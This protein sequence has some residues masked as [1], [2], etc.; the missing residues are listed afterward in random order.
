M[1]NNWIE[2]ELETTDLND[3]RLDKRLSE[4][5]DT[6]AARPHFSIPAACGGYAETMAAYRFF[7]NEKTNF[8]NVLQPH[9][10][11]TEKRFAKHDTVL[12]V[13]DTTELNLTR[14]Q[15]QIRGAG[16][17]GE[18]SNRRGAYLHLLAA[19]SPDA[20]PLGAVWAKTIVRE[21]KSETETS[22]ER[23][24]KLPFLPI[25]EKESIRWL[26][27]VRKTCDAAKRND[28]TRFVCVGDSE[29]DIFEVFAEP[30]PNHVHL[31]IRACQ[32][33]SV[34][35]E[36]EGR[37]HLRDAVMASPVRATKTIHVRGRVPA[38]SCC[39]SPRQQP[40]KSRDAEMEVRTASLTV[41]V[42]GPLKSKYDPVAMN[43]VSLTEKNPPSGDVPI[44]WIL[45]T[46][47]P[48]DT[49]EQVFEAIGYYETRW[50]I[51]VFFKTLKS[52]C[53]V[54]SL[55]F[56]TMDRLTPCLAVYLIV[57]WRVLLL[58]RLGR[59]LPEMNCEA[60]FDESEWK[61]L[62]RIRNPNDAIPKTPPTLGEMLRWVGE[63]GGWVSTP[64]KQEMPGPQTTWIGLQRLKDFASA[65]RLFGPEA[66]K[67]K[68]DV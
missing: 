58:C 7:E 59:S 53:K 61:S 2:N 8:E 22:A 16:P 35:T 41:N 57:A 49:L 64:G 15:Q 56:E 29:C 45:L 25:E 32:D 47:L 40:R 19:F 68:K 9:L 31:L 38:V 3:K 1:D 42:P 23:Q 13:Q 24:R 10:D 20:V 43:V 37:D 62:Y 11:A 44:E 52:G 12:C 65:W 46:T 26:E 55:Q 4:I 63:L 14:P 67:Y 48:I 66:E 51:E 5:L 39:K 50:M 27:A 60:L 28:A 36:N 34:T 17:I 21:E 54:E 30:R 18:G 33:R 6:L